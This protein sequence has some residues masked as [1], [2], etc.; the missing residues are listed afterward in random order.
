MGT[1]SPGHNN[2][3][4]KLSMDLA[5][6]FSSPNQNSKLRTFS[7]LN[8][9]SSFLQHPKPGISTFQRANQQQLLRSIQIED[10]QVQVF[11][12]Q[13]ESNSGNEPSPIIKRRNQHGFNVARELSIYTSQKNKRN[14]LRRDS[15]FSQPDT[16]KKGSKTE[17]GI[18]LE[19]EH[20]ASDELFNLKVAQR[21]KFSQNV[22]QQGAQNHL[23]IRNNLEPQNTDRTI[24]ELQSP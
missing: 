23:R 4:R 1:E 9:K 18:I 22:A 12:S 8:Q 24:S 6:Q 20:D 15:S 13:S 5:N 2:N 19:S 11:D 10:S 7:Q 17:L 3:L 16:S 14:Y 21:R